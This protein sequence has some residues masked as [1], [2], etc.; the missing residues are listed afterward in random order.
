MSEQVFENIV[1]GSGP[2]AFAAA[3]A[4]KNLGQP[5]LVLDVGNEPSRPLQDEISELSRIDPSEWPPSVRDELFPLPRTSAEGVDKRHAFGSGFVY[6]VPE[7]ERIVCSNCIVDVSFARGGFGNVWGAA[8]LPFSS[9]ELA[10]WPIDVGKM[11]D[12]YKRVLRYVPLC[13]GP[14]SLQRSFPLWA[15]KVGILP[16]S[17]IGKQLKTILS[18]RKKRSIEILVGRARLAVNAF[19]EN[20]QCRLC[21]YCL[22]GC[23][24][25]SIFN[26]RA[27]WH[28]LDPQGGN[29]RPNV[30][31]RSFR[32]DGDAVIVEAK[33]AE[34][35]EP[36]AFRANRLFLA[37]GAVNSTA[38]TARSL[39]LTN[40][41]IPLKDA[42]YFFFPALLRRKARIP[43]ADRFTLAEHFVEMKGPASEGRWVHFQVYPHNRIFGATLKNQLGPLGRLKP[44][45]DFFAGRFVLFQGF[46]HSDLS[47]GLSLT[48]ADDQIRI[49]GIPNKKS[50]KTAFW[51]A[52]NIQRILKWHAIALIP[53]LKMVAPGRSFHIG[54]S[55]PMKPEAT[56]FY[57]D[58]K[59]QPMGTTNV[60][61]VDAASFTSIPATTYALSLMAHAD[62]IVH[63]V[64][65]K[66]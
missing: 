30:L 17:P 49:E 27:Y 8:A 51:A 46:L 7:G 64:H 52:L 5:Y 29:Y 63:A 24:Y 9:T 2:S 18:A 60:H 44:L 6:D 61:L 56:G 21:G 58:A 15:K 55:F 28:H 65:A 33:D 16:L 39:G 62:R 25:G 35:G 43:R 20:Q 1:V 19:S 41:R 38:I 54:S 11:Q 48:A 32:K 3:F 22:D 66:P 59:G 40:Q 26:P 47:P 13:G 53:A 23:V 42:Q 31:V 14:D 34:T 45:L 12:A 36:I 57:S 50:R 4:L 10:D 37:A